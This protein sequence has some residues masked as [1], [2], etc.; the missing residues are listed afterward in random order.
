MADDR[1][2]DDRTE[3]EVRQTMETSARDVFRRW[4]RDIDGDELRRIGF[5]AIL[6]SSEAAEHFADMVRGPLMEA[7][8]LEVEKLAARLMMPPS[9]P[10]RWRWFRR[11][12]NTDHLPPHAITALIHQLDRRRDDG[13][14]R[15]IA[16][17][18]VRT[19]L[20]AG[21]RALED[22]LLLIDA[23]ERTI[24]AGARE[25]RV[26]NP[27]AAATVQERGSTMLLERR[28]AVMTQLAIHR[29]S[30]MTLD[31]LMANQQ[32]LNVALERTRTAT[33]SALQVASAAKRATADAAA[34][35]AGATS[36]QVQRALHEALRHARTAIETANH[37]QNGSVLDR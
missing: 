26:G 23:L 28:Q 1:F 35:Q 25:L 30:M 11:S 5:I 29:Q 21:E 4:M 2:I 14:R 24:E 8:L 27:G 13:A 19:R 36:A 9:P 7:V 31:L 20:N 6:R 10:T 3:L 12:G 34:L 32:T 16:L 22:V 18:T 33:L 17:K 15:I 37:P